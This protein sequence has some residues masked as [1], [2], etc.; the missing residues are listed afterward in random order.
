MSSRYR[1]ALSSRENR[2]TQPCHDL[3]VRFNP[4]RIDLFSDR[5]HGGLTWIYAWCNIIRMKNKTSLK[6]ESSGVKNIK[7]QPDQFFRETAVEE[8]SGNVWTGFNNTQKRVLIS[9]LFLETCI[10]KLTIWKSKFEKRFTFDVR[11]SI[12]KFPRERIER[13]NGS[14]VKSRSKLRRFR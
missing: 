6:T 4:F 2:V 11:G 13:D 1:T 5:F 10:N 14:Q 7:E 9:S 12:W 8:I 3:D